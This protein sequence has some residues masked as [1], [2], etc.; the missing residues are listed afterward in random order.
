VIT[1][2]KIWLI[3]NEIVLID[4]LGLWRIEPRAAAES[5]PASLAGEESGTSGDAP[6]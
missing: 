6:P 2:L 4:R 1:A 3:L 5:S